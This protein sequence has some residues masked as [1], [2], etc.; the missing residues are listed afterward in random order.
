MPMGLKS[1]R[2]VAWVALVAAAACFGVDTTLSAF[3]LRELR[4]AD[5]FVTETTIGMV[6]LWGWM[7]LRRGYRRP[8]RLWPHVLLGLIEPGIVY[9]LFDVGLRRTSAVTGGL[10]VSTQTLFA[11]L[12]AV[13]F[14]RERLG[15][16]GR[17][18]VGTGIV[19]AVLVSARAGGGHGS[20][21]GDMYVLIASATGSTYYLVARGLGVDDDALSGTAIQLAASWVLALVFAVVSWPASGTALPSASAAHVLVAVATGVIGITVPYYL[22]NRALKTTEGSTAALLLNLIPVFAVVSAVGF[23]GEAVMLTT[24]L[25]GGLILAGLVVLARTSVIAVETSA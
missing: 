3:A 15:A 2:R 24:I 13:V 14:L 20:L 18:A 9:L 1:D 17:V 22:V 4:P 8:R 25:G 11:V 7:L 5:L 16:A 19:G 6:S 12:L 21:V 10:L 23:L